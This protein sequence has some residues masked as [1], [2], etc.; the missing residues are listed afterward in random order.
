MKTPGLI[1]D[2]F[3]GGGGASTGI[4]AAL[5]WPIDVAINHDS[6][7]IAMHQANHPDTFHYCQDVWEVD[8]LECVRTASI[9]R[10]G[11]P[12]LPVALAWFSPDCKHFSKAKGGKPREKSIRDLAWV[13]HRWIKALMPTDQHPHVIMLENVEEFRT[14]GPL[15]DCGTPCK[16]RK[17]ETFLEWVQQL[18]DHG[19]D[20]QW[21]EIRACDFG[22]PTSRRR[23]FLIARRDS[24]P[25]I[26]PARTHGPGEPLGWR[27]AADIID[28]SIP[29]PSIFDRKRPLRDKTLR[30]IALGIKRFVIDAARPFVVPVTHAG[31]FERVHS[32]D[33][34]LRTITG[35]NRGELGLVAPTLVGTDYINTRASRAFDIQ[36]PVRTITT[37]PSYALVAAFLAQHNGGP[38]NSN[39][40]GRQADQPLSTITGRGTQQQLVTS[41]LIKLRNHSTAGSVEQPL[42]TITA[43]GGHH[44]EVRA[45]LI[46][47]YGNEVDGHEIEA[48]LGTVTTKDR[49]GLVTVIVDGSEYAI[50]D[51]GMRML[52]ARELFNAQGFPK[53]Y[54]IDRDAQG[55]PI[56]K[57]SQVARCGNSVCPQVPQAL[58]SHNL[59]H[60]CLNQ[61]I[62]A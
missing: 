21:R 38:R 29:C 41:N 5:G 59:P 27:T 28:W 50:A 32:I 51:I 16:A 36:D 55:K 33:E 61:R 24:N 12:N 19:Y 34:P 35:A 10:A 25:I 8:P 26:W 2:N 20:V 22:A 17:G 7:A 47:Y 44:A 4:E 15:L 60:L 18:R 40:S 39:I 42:G 49:F 30:R 9:R 57:T 31:G 58:V 62:A 54:I 46:K 1:I 23:M 37:Q 52:S 3:A 11:H 13:V 48:P 43:S 53:H 56:T 6:E 14:W 45:L